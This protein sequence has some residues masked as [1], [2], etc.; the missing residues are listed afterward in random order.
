MCEKKQKTSC[1]PNK[2]PILSADNKPT[3]QTNNK[4]QP[5]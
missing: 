1:N 5:I 2:N 4:Q 3:S